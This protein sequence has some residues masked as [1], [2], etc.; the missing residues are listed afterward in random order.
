M[1]KKTYF[2]SYTTRTE[3]D[4]QWAVW[5]EWFFRE[6]L[7]A[8]TIMQEYDFKPGDNF[9]IKMNEALKNAD[10]VVC[11]LTRAYLGSVN[12]QEEWTNAKSF[13][14]IKFDECDPDGLL[15]CRSYI[16]LCGLGQDAARQ[17]LLAALT[18]KVRLMDEPFFPNRTEPLFPNVEKESV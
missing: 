4:R 2:I 8:E 10:F 5:T 18:D 15:N 12:C 9:K 3:A 14:P 17:T 7:G 16:N 6:K 11:V 13:I 1:D